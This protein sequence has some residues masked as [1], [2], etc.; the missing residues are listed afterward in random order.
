MANLFVLKAVL[1]LDSSEYEQGIDNAGKKA[2]V[3]SEV[4]KANLVTKGVEVAVTGLKKLGSAAVNVIQQSV[5]AFADYEQL[6]GG[7][8]TLFKGSA[9]AVMQY[10]ADAYKTA[11][12]SANQYMETVTSFS[13]SLI[14]SLGGNTEQ[15]AELANVAIQ[16]M[17]DNANKM[18]SSID[19][20][21][22]AYA[23]FA[24]Q[25]YTINLMSAA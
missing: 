22:V 24:K 4:L 1:G 23:G 11:G 3:F 20:I 7:V 25:N 9:D 5:D 21:Q 10:A 14:Q 15:A 17:S 16:D 19:S 8:E 12:L 18:G 2:S 13:A 6:A